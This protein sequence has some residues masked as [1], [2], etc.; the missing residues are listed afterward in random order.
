MILYVAD[1]PKEMATSEAGSVL[2]EQMHVRRAQTREDS[3]E[4]CVGQHPPCC[5]TVCLAWSLE[6]ERRKRS[7]PEYATKTQRYVACVA[8][9]HIIV[10]SELQ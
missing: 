10:V 6:L 9:A 5:P 1:R 8:A 2:N 4:H 3:E 7:C